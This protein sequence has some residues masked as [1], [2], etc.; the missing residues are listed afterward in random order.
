LKTPSPE[1]SRDEKFL[2]KMGWNKNMTKDQPLNLIMLPKGR[3]DSGSMVDKT[4]ETEER[5]VTLKY[6]QAV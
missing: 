4:R 2:Y 1:E 6:E 5:S 3:M